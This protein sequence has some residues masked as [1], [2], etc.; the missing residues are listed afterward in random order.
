M[1]VDITTYNDI[2][3]EAMRCR[4][5]KQA[6]PL[7]TAILVMAKK[8]NEFME[9]RSQIGL[10]IKAA[11]DDPLFPCGFDADQTEMKGHMLVQT[12]SGFSVEDSS[13]QDVLFGR[14]GEDVE[15][16]YR[17]SIWFIGGS[18]KGKSTLS[19]AIGRLECV[20][21]G[22][23]LY[24]S[25][26]GLDGL[27]MFTKQGYM[28][29]FAA[30]VISDFT[31]SFGLNLR[32]DEASIKSLLGTEEAVEHQARYFPARWPAE[33]LRI[34]SVNT[35]KKL[36]TDGVEV[37]EIDYGNFF[38]NH[39]CLHGVGFL[40]N[41]DMEALQRCSDDQLSFCR[42]VIL[43]RLSPENT[44]KPISKD[45]HAMS[46][47]RAQERRERYHA[48]LAANCSTGKMW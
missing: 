41:K 7:Q 11:Q 33:R 4:Y 39:R 1:K 25:G 10:C 37:D 18:G 42:R 47:A 23:Q 12:D 21:Q 26:K 15:L 9:F 29:Q 44:I 32:M 19:D 3:A 35:G 17:R 24:F 22:L 6:D 34:F 38:F 2:V 46:V 45:C 36:N 43:F 40:A 28:Q 48:F 16:C 13:L 14:P 20:R 8:A 31:F 27:R 30:F 5:L